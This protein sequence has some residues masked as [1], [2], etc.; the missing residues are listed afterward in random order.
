M[1]KR[2]DDVARWVALLEKKHAD[3][4]SPT[5]V[6]D[7]RKTISKRGFDFACPGRRNQKPKDRRESERLRPRSKSIIE[8][9][10]AVAATM[11]HPRVR[12]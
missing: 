8:S 3:G 4:V 1:A 5:P 6:G 12:S 2:S 10:A 7:T 11:P 9:G